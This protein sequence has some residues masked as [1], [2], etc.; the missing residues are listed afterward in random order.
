MHIAAYIY[1]VLAVFTFFYAIH[2][3]GRTE[4][5]DF[6]NTAFAVLMVFLLYYWGGFFVTLGW[7]QWFMFIWFCMM[8]LKH[9][10]RDG[11]KRIINFWER[12][13]GLGMELLLLSSG[14]FFTSTSV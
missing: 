12:L 14:G 11:E 1:I 9:Y 13:L 2:M 4:K 7:P 3:H 8:L 6:K 5:Y 10:G